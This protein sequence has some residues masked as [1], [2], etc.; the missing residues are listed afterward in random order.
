MEEKGKEGEM[1]QIFFVKKSPPSHQFLFLILSLS[2]RAHLPPSS[3][4]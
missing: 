3:L 1:Y 2:F 4:R